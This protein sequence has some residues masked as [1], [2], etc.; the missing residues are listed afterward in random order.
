MVLLSHNIK[1]CFIHLLKLASKNYKAHDKV[2]NMFANLNA[3]NSN[4]F[5]KHPSQVE[6]SWNNIFKSLE[7]LWYMEFC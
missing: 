2:I 5:I 1:P 6:D 7:L 3:V 4:V